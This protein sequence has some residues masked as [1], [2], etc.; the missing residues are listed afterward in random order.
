[1]RFLPVMLAA[2]LSLSGQ[3]P[4]LKPRPSAQLDFPS[5]LDADAARASR[6]RAL[7]WLVRNQREDG[8]WAHGVI[9]GLLDSGYAVSAFYDWKLGA[10]ALAI[11]ALRRCP[12]TPARLAA[13]RKAIRWFTTARLPKRGNDWDNDS[14]WAVLYGVVMLVEMTDDPRF[15]EAPWGPLIRD[16]GQA[17]LK[18]LI[19]NQI[20]T[21]GWAYYDDPPYSR[22]PKWGTSF[23]TA[24]IL[25]TL[26]RAHAAGWFANRR[27]IERAMAYVKRCRLPNGAYEYDLNPI[28]RAPSGDHINNIKGSLGRIQVCNWALRSCGDP[29]T[30]DERITAGLAQLMKHHRFLDIARMRPI[31]HEAYY[32]N[33]G[34]FYFF[35]HYYAAEVIQLLPEPQREKWH[36]RL[37]PHIVKTQRKDGSVCDFLGQDYLIVAGAAY[38][39]L[40]LQLG[41]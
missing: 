39:A 6:D 10:N 26:Q 28:P 2:C 13:L 9:T 14:M 38:A 12:Q 11:M 3:V 36:A 20:P 17:L 24:M 30:T 25:P 33:A 8:S 18:V 19:K 5:T 7:G 23:C 32:A 40:T 4:D 29:K 21:G 35:G 41:L 1:M 22:R 34:Y 37:R 31:P 27:V 15:R 16:R